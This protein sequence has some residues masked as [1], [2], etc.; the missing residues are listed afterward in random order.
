MNNYMT[1]AVAAELLREIINNISTPRADGHSTQ[2]LLYRM[3]L[4]KAI[5]VLEERG[6]K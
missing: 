5:E 6:E 4:C 3:A 1:D 2:K